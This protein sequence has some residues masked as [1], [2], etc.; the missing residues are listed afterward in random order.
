MVAT[1]TR[2]FA[3]VLSNRPK[4]A[5]LDI[6]TK[7]CH[8]S[9]IS[10]AV[11]PAALRRFIPERFSIDTV[12]IDGVER[13]LLSVVPFED[14]DFTSAVLPFPKFRFGQT[15]YRAYITDQ[16][17]GEKAVWFLGTVLDSWTVSIPRYLWRL[18]WHRGSVQFFVELTGNHYSSYSMKTSSSWAPAEV[19]LEPEPMNLT[20]P[21]FP[22][23]E[24]AL[25]F[26]THP[27]AGFYHRTDGVLGS[28]RVWHDR[29]DVSWGK[30][31]SA[32]FELLDRLGLVQFSAQNQ[33]H[34]VLI[35]PA[36]EFTIYLPPRVH[37]DAA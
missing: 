23:E 19:E 27:L 21:G 24:T 5:G 13:A 16:R 20:P 22:D 11:D 18:P 26:L 1:P 31:R 28:Y 15:N 30:V 35:Q 36:P 2:R 17:T 3:E 25:V 37:R 12:E 10:Y 7:L 34:S 32:R 9:I 6:V 14:V 8:F 4:P 33:P 29:L